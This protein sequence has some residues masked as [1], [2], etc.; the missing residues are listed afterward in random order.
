[1]P[2]LLFLIIV[3]LIAQ[4]GFWETLGAVLGAVGMVIL[5]ILLLVAAVTLGVYLT[6]RRSRKRL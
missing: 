4:I 2:L 6:V 1:M 3:L 5:L